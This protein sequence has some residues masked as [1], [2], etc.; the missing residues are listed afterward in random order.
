MSAS[1]RLRI[2]RRG[3]ALAVA[4]GLCAALSLGAA[5]QRLGRT[6]EPCRTRDDCA[7]GLLCEVQHCHRPGDPSAVGLQPM[8]FRLPHAE[9]PPR[10]METISEAVQRAARE[11]GTPVTADVFTSRVLPQKLV[12][13]SGVHYQP[14]LAARRLS[15]AVA[16]LA[17]EV[18]GFALGRKVTLS[19]SEAAAQGMVA[20]KNETDIPIVV[21][22]ALRSA[23]RRE[24]VPLIMDP[25]RVDYALA[26]GLWRLQQR[27]STR[28]HIA[29]V[30]VAGSFC[31]VAVPLE[32]P[33]KGAWSDGALARIREVEALFTERREAIVAALRAQGLEP[34]AMQPRDGIPPDAVAVVLAGPLHPLSDA[35]V[36][37]LRSLRESNRGLVVLLPGARQVASSQRFAAVEADDAPLLDALGL[38][39]EHGLLV[40]RSARTTFK[41]PRPGDG[42]PQP[43]PLAV[44]AVDIAEEHD[45]TAGLTE[46]S[47]PLARSF[48]APQS[49]ERT[50]LYWGRAATSA[51]RLP[52]DASAAAVEAAAPAVVAT[53]RRALAVAIDARR[54]GRTVVIGSDLGLESMSAEQLLEKLLAEPPADLETAL[55]GYV[56]AAKA[57]VDAGTASADLRARAVR[58]LHSAVLW[59]G[60]PRE[61]Q[62]LIP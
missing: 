32:P 3:R 19:G 60:V 30:C 55:A 47:L 22:A 26:A 39:A 50:V 61:I 2:R 31:P 52:V 54:G 38:K 20:V 34:L 46:L 23:D 16:A 24:A 44:E 45:A 53:T 7:F 36:S 27:I 25:N 6:G 28:T 18:D 41:V 59:V 14:E 15:S 37:W 49:P 17:R 9:T 11:V 51:V 40:D 1:H 42:M 62:E 48:V 10:E 57:Y 43:L 8:L 33:R 21:G 58:A 56:A 4:L 35:D 12:S 29:F 13:A 5:C